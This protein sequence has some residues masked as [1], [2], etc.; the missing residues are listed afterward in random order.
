[1]APSKHVLQFYRNI[2]FIYAI[3]DGTDVIYHIMLYLAS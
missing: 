2:D 1:L 3:F